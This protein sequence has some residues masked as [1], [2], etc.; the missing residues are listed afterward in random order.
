M[1]HDENQIWF[2]SVWH[3]APS[4]PKTKL[5]MKKSLVVLLPIASYL[6]LATTV[7]LGGLNYPGYSH[8]SQ[9][10]SEL[11]ATGAPHASYVNYFG[12]LP[13]EIFMLLFA[14]IVWMVLPA[15]KLKIAGLL[16]LVMYGLSFVVAAFYPCDF[17]CRPVEPSASHLLHMGF[18]MAAYFFGVLTIYLLAWDSQRWANSKLP[19]ISGMVIATIALILLPNYDPELATVG[20][21]QRTAETLI[22]I[23]FVILAC[24]M[25]RA[26]P[27]DKISRLQS[28]TELP[29]Q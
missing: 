17:Q 23:W 11:A 16:S 29:T 28:R 3:A 26:L 7:V 22:Y 20:L 5:K 12:F 9:F 24:A 13:T 14:A 10:I 27:G 1:V 8:V 21:V 19:F 18:G 25:Y 4:S 2:S 15:S 6:W